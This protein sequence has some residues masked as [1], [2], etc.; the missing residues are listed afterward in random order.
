MSRPRIL[1]VGAGPA[2]L[3]AAAEA[4]DLGCAVT[5][6]DEGER[7]GGQIHRQPPEPLP[8]AAPELP[9][10]KAR[11][12][13]VL[14]RF[15]AVADAI[16]YR[17]RTIVTAFYGLDQILLAD[18]SASE[19]AAADAVVL[20]TGVHEFVVPFDGWTLPGVVTAG[21]VQAQLK[22]GAVRVGDRIAF[23]GTGPL[24]LVA[25]SQALAAGAAVPAVVLLK[26]WWRLAAGPRTLWTGRTALGEGLRHLARLHRAGVRIYGGHV[27]VR[28]VGAAGVERLVIARHGGD[29]RP[30]SGTEIRIDVDTVAASFGFTANSDLA[31][32]AG[33]ETR[34]DA[35]RGGWLPVRDAW[36]ATSVPGLFVAG[37]GSGVAG[38]LAAAADGVV[39]GAAAAGWALHRDARRFA[40]RTTAAVAARAGHWRVP[41]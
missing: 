21:A 41:G 4:A 6:V 29:G 30:L 1:V 9:S 40:G 5:L 19:L 15:A 34:F 37:D 26:P 32:M 25:A 31:R 22:G 38:A 14:A 33:A 8:S 20:A 23:V 10:E 7:P 39:A 17:P 24:P 12:A 13:R 28:A 35:R 18:P 16:D 36:G 3:M 11:K 2:G 27:P